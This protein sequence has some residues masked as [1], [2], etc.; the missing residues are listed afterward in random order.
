MG[1]WYEQIPVLVNKQVHAYT[2]P[3][4]ENAMSYLILLL[5]SLLLFPGSKNVVVK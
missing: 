2:A 4:L 3:C 1:N 5:Q